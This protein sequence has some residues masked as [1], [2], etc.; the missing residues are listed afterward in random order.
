MSSIAVETRGLGRRFGG[1]WA[2]RDCS[3]SLPTGGVTGLV[4]P[5]GAGKT[6]LLRLA[7]GALP[8]SAG[9]IEVRGRAVSDR[10]ESLAEIGFVAQHKPL[11]SSFTVGEMLRFGAELNPRWEG[12]RAIRH[13]SDLGIDTRQKAGKLSGGQRAQVALA[14]ALGKRPRLLLLD[15]PVANLDPLA[16]RQFFG[17]LM[18]EVAQT[19]V[20]VVLSS[21]LL[22][23]LDRSC[24]YL[25]LLSAS[26]VQLSGHTEE[27][28]A[29]HRW[30]SGPADRA[31][32][33]AAQHTIVQREVT[34]RLAR[35]LIRAHGPVFDLAWSSREPTLE[36]LVLAY[37]D[38][39]EVTAI[40][41][42]ALA[43]VSQ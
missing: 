20:T 12:A 39:P 37:M 2:L 13:L 18:Q 17:G 22:E 10:P 14:L 41:R 4:G 31:P 9:E 25:V 36:E 33:I 34:G 43:P 21:H 7:A 11:Y 28:V 29:A 32:A 1:H 40:E 35:L 38:R 15:E 19:D 23:D 6:T 26:R 30:L 3:L 5:N 42:L 24:D 27:L 16:R 8:A